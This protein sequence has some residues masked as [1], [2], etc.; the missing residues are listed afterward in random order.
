MRLRN[1]DMAVRL[2]AVR[3]AEPDE[4]GAQRAVL[5]EHHEIAE[6]RLCH[7]VDESHPLHELDR[8]IPILPQQ[9]L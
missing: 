6:F 7:P 9:R 8:Q 4:Q 2:H 5:A 1:D 3:I